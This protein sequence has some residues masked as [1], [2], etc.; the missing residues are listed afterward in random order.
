MRRRVDAHRG[1]GYARPRHRS[2]SRRAQPYQMQAYC[3]RHGSGACGRT[4]RPTRY[5]PSPAVRS[6]SAHVGSPARSSAK[7]RSWRMPGLDDILISYP[8]I[9]P[10]KAMRLAALA[11]RVTMRVAVDNPLALETAAQ[12]AR[13][14]GKPIGVLVEFDSGNKRTGVVS[15]DQALGLARR[16]CRYRGAA[17]RWVDDLS[18]FGA[19]ATFV[20]KAK[21]C[22]PRP[23]RRLPSCPAAARRRR[24]MRMRSPG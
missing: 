13:A 10:V 11:D 17:V 21:P 23:A 22:S 6:S 14:S 16:H 19:T 3:D 5:R 2:R 18:E 20:A 12:A 4:S 1:S 15:V 8:L 7:P 9:G 24:G